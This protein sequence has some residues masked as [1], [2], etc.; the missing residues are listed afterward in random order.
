MGSNAVRLLLS[1]VFISTGP[2]VIKKIS[3]IR[4]PLRMGDDAFLNRQI[5]SEKIHALIEM[6][7]G[8]RHLIDAYNPVS[9]M[10]CATSALR[11]SENGQEIVGKIKKVTGMS[12]QIIDGQRE[13]EIIYS[14]HIA[15]YLKN[16]KEYLYVDVGGGSTEITCFN[17]S[18][19]ARSASFKIGT[20]RLLNKLVPESAWHEMKIWLKEN[21]SGADQINVI[22]SGGN[23]NKLYRLSDQ[24]N[25]KPISYNKLKRIESFLKSFSTDERVS[26][27]GLR[28]DRADVIIPASKIYLSVM[29][30][31]KASNIYVPQIGLVDGMIHM[32]YETHKQSNA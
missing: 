6:M 21:T 30:W 31:A 32:L 27:L 5:S 20:I 13:A 4:M 17:N 25:N 8:F 1:Q 15:G 10:A 11:E 26:R 7:K 3:L 14:T 9:Y 16:N 19:P 18:G 23:I 12:I 28:P 2:P 22:G 29:K 24:K